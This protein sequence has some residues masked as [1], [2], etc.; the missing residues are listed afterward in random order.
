MSRRP[1]FLLLVLLAATCACAQSHRTIA[2]TFDDL[3]KATAPG[4]D[5][6]NITAI[7]RTNDQL[8]A[9]LRSHHAPAI[10]FVNES[11]LFV[12]GQTDARIA[13]LQAW[14][15][16]GMQ[17]GNHTFSHKDLNA[18]SLEE[19][20]DDVIHG[21]VVWHRLMEQSSNGGV[22]AKSGQ[23]LYFRHPFTHTGETREKKNAFEAF[24][25]SRGYVVAPFTV[26][27]FDYGFNAI[28]AKALARGDKGQAARI[29]AAY[30]D[31]LDTMLRF[32]EQK[33]RELFGR[34][35]PQALLIHDN[36]INAAS[37]D[38]M[39]TRME[40]RGYSFVTL[41]EAMCDPA[42]ATKDYYV[43]RIGPSWLHRWSVALGKPMNFQA[44][45]D[46]P[47]W[48]MDLYNAK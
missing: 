19:Y 3:P 5:S 45:P 14:L 41:G 12:A 37:L 15:D 39:L 2:L 47:K 24:L 29:R 17:L 33:S 18:V 46:P 6:N 23:T 30:L 35:I 9:V 16:A 42:Y 4:Q 44:E 40:K 8:L 48:V 38:A 1:C 25:K 13:I 32:F 26:E 22:S 20:E 10:G 27:H 31:H 7:R 34:E 21:E 36:D 28:Y 11:K 43:G